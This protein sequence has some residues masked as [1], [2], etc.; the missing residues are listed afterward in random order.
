M[1]PNGY[2]GFLA[3]CILVVVLAI[4]TISENFHKNI[5]ILILVVIAAGITPW[6]RLFKNKRLK[7]EEICRF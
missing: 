3:F 4:K 6:L 1:V 2:G 5:G 7:K